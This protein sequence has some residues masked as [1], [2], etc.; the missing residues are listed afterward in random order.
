MPKS[1]YQKAIAF[2]TSTNPI[3][4]S[5]HQTAIAPHHNKTRSPIPS[6]QTAI[7]S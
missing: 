1:Q 5:P 4:Y 7:A 2:S 3:A 6:N